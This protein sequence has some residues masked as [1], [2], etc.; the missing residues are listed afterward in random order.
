MRDTYHV[1]MLSRQTFTL[2]HPLKQG[3]ATV[4]TSRIAWL[5]AIAA[6]A[7]FLPTAPVKAANLIVM[8]G[9]TQ[10]TSTVGASIV[11]GD[12]FNWSFTLDLDSTATG[13]NGYG[14]GSFN[15][16]V[17]AF[18]LSADSGN[19]G[20]W[21]PAGVNWVI[22]PVKN[23]ATNAGGDQMSFQIQATNAPPIDSIAFYDLGITLDWDPSEVDV[24]PV[25]GTPSLGT[26]LGTFSPDL[27]A[28][29]YYFE[30]RD[31]NYSSANFVVPSV[32]TPSGSTLTASESQSQTFELSFT[33][34][35]G[36]TCSNSS[37]SGTGGTWVTL[38]GASDCTAPETRSDANLLGW[39]TTPNFP[40]DIAKRQL[41]N[42][43]GAYETFDDTGHI[44]SVFIPAG[45]ATFLSAQG[46]LY[47]IWAD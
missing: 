16:A 11:T 24:Q 28:A 40:I 42:G 25:S 8:S 13:S 23:L 41:D 19:V 21:S 29:T 12:M 45:G 14:G 46:N 22:S 37:Q 6:F 33:P 38:P 2:L 3:R 30:L 43:W 35:D 34:E 5:A 39:A 17:T 1:M 31:T 10:A 36:T 47:P 15:N 27:T 20:T 9:T 18:T 32:P 26:T 4:S 7:L 44:T